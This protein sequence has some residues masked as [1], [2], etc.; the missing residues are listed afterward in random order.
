MCRQR[1]SRVAV[2][3]SCVVLVACGGNGNAA[4]GIGGDED[5]FFKKSTNTKHPS[6]VDPRLG[7]ELVAVESLPSSSAAVATAGESLACERAALNGSG[8]G[9]GLTP[10]AEVATSAAAFIL[11]AADGGRA[12]SLVNSADDGRV[13]AWR[14]DASGSRLE[15][16]VAVRFEGADD[17]AWADHMAVNAACLPSGTA[18]VA[19]SYYA[20]KPGAALFLF[21]PATGVFRKKADIDEYIGGVDQFLEARAVSPESA[22]LV[23]YSDRT[24]AAPE[25]Y[26]NLYN[27]VLLFSP[28]YAEGLEVLTLGIDDGNV[29]EWRVVGDTLYLRTVDRRDAE[30]HRVH[31][32][33]LDLS[34]V[35]GG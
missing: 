9:A 22:L 31:H 15:A 25:V 4:S 26:H 5:M 11:P 30:N 35:L 6:R 17:S 7:A 3:V 12:H 23:Y 27:H 33:A 16:E 13:E 18:A 14:L 34:A 1:A 32:W 10:G 29:D 20:R 8:A 24:R 28:E 2:V 21:D 19:V